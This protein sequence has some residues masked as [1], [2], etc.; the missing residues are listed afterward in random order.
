MML[1]INAIDYI[2]KNI[3]QERIFKCFGS[4]NASATMI[5]IKQIDAYILIY[6]N[7]ITFNLFK[8]NTLQK[9]FVRE[10]I[11]KIFPEREIMY[12]CDKDC[13]WL[14]EIKEKKLIKSHCT[15]G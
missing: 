13:S 6:D 8:E 12:T 11:R 5:M 14:E 15:Q 7:S 3:F 4:D 10:C 2:P 1:S 9:E